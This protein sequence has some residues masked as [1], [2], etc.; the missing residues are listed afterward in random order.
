MSRPLW[1]RGLKPASYG[2]W[3]DDSMSPPSWVRGLKH[4]WQAWFRNVVRVALFVG[5]WIETSARSRHR[6]RMSVAPF[7]GAW[8]ETIQLECAA[9]FSHVALFMGA[10]TETLVLMRLTCGS[11]VALFG[12]CG[13]KLYGRT[14]LLPLGKSHS[15]ECVD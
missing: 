4:L 1:V 7:M 6:P 13:L 2:A 5:A 8:I 14:G 11:V 10:W 3:N 9:P 15:S 12:V